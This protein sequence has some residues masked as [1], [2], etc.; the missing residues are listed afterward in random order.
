[1]PIAS[2]MSTSGNPLAQHHRQDAAA[3]RAE[4]HPDA[5]LLRALVDRE[6]D[7]AGDPR[8]GDDQ[9][10]QGE[11]AEQRRRQP[12]WRERRG[13]HL[14]QRAELSTGWFGIDRVHGVADLAL[15]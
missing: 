1:M 15:P 8:R 5:E 10:E 6:G 4:R 13:A 2:P 3:L 11:E 9:R 14:G 12:R 7:D